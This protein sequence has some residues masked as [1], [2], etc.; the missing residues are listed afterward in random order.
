MIKNQMIVN[1]FQS[2]FNHENFKSTL[3]LDVTRILQW[4]LQ[5]N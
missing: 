5:I 3:I 2:C 4:Q 1:I